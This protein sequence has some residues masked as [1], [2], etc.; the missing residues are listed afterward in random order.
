M[1]A[2]PL[3][4]AAHQGNV[5]TVK[6]LIAHGYNVNGKEEVIALCILN[7]HVICEYHYQDYNAKQSMLQYHRLIRFSICNHHGVCVDIF[8]GTI[9]CYVVCFYCSCWWYLLDLHEYFTYYM[10]G[11]Q[12]E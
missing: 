4:V 2:T 11:L 5:D 12:G 7:A 6:T 8:H 1:V 3:H 9:V 10:C